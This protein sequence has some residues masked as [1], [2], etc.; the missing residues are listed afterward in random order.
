MKKNYFGL[1]FLLLLTSCSMEQSADTSFE[2]IQN[3]DSIS[4]T[5]QTSSFESDENSSGGPLYVGALPGAFFYKEIE[6]R[7]NREL[8]LTDFD[9]EDLIAIIINPSD[10]TKFLSE[11]HTCDYII[12]DSTYNYYD[13]DNR[14]YV[15]KYENYE[16]N[17]YLVVFTKM[18][19]SLYKSVL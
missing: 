16:I 15:Y 7:Y 3:N 12:Y 13:E 18:D 1:I 19:S 6:Y 10:E 9:E 11:N 5:S 14:L 17:E 2:S 8:K 4:N